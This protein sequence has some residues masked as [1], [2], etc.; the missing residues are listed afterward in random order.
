MTPKTATNLFLLA[1]AAISMAGCKSYET[2]TYD[3]TVRNDTPDAIV[4]WL[5]KDG[6][7]Y[8]SGWLSPEDIAIQSPKANDPELAGAIVAAG[9]TADTGTRKGRF[10]PD[11]HAIL[12]V[13]QGQL[14]FS[15]ILATSRGDPMRIDLQLPPGRS[16]FIVRPAGSL[17]TVQ[18][19][20]PFGQ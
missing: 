11:T 13:Y 16:E 2:R 17:I 9:K 12:R 20:E 3:V 15:E 1:L 7:P 5:T 4:V 19:V 18:R 14:K 8:E 6:A 10:E